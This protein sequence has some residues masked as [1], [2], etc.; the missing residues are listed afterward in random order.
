[1]AKARIIVSILWLSRN[2]ILNPR[3]TLFKIQDLLDAN[4]AVKKNKKLRRSSYFWDRLKRKT[5]RVSVAT[6]DEW[7]YML[8]KERA[9]PTLTI[10]SCLTFFFIGSGIAIGYIIWGT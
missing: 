1:M 4:K 2:I 10:I 6:A 3:S 9:I 7:K 8:S 5:H